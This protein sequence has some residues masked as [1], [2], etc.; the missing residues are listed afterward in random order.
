MRFALRVPTVNV[1]VVDL[2]F[3]AKR[4]TS[5]SEVNAIVKAASD[6]QVLAYNE[7]P[8]VSTD[9][10][11][12]SASSNFDATQTRVNGNLVKILTW[13]D[14]EWGFSCR[15]IDTALAMMKA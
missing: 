13:Y 3:Q 11:H 6:G 2:T 12:Q 1:S 7:E 4:E 15:M 14:N 8:L 10:N 5:L 9:F